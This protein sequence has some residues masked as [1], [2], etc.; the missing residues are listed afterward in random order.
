[1]PSCMDLLYHSVTVAPFAFDNARFVGLTDNLF[2]LRMVRID[3]EV[4][5]ADRSH[6]LWL[7]VRFPRASMFVSNFSSS[8]NQSI[9]LS[10]CFEDQ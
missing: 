10:R 7:V 5:G 6:D 2:S 3:H 4:G 9:A 8:S 1:M